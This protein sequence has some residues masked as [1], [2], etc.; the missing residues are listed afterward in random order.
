MP[1]SDRA[2]TVLLCRSL[3]HDCARMAIED[4]L[5]PQWIVYHELVSA[6]RTQ[7]RKVCAIEHK[8]AT[9][10]LEKLR[11]MQTARLATS[12]AAGKGRGGG[13]AAAAETAAEEPG[14]A[15]EGRLEVPKA[16]A[17]RLEEARRRALAR[18]AKGAPGKA[19]ARR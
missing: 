9:P 6:A 2:I 3:H 14:G 17:Q 11:D 15:R 10:V 7:L 16:D 18:R 12:G 13:A 1:A 19:K 5:L 8:W 4:G